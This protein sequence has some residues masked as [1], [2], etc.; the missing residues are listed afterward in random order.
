MNIILIFS[1]EPEEPDGRINRVRFSVLHGLGNNFINPLTVYDRH[2]QFEFS[3]S[4]IKQPFDK[5]IGCVTFN[6]IKNYN[7][8]KA[9][10][11]PK[12]IKSIIKI[13][14]G[15]PVKLPDTILFDCH[16]PI[17]DIP[18]KDLEKFRIIS[19]S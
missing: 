13:N 19:I 15:T 11:D 8:I 18:I 3:R 6:H 7:E 2:G 9:L 17:S 16:F 12:L 1:T 10:T 4:I 5:R 14:H